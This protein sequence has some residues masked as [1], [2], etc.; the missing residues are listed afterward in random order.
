MTWNYR[1]FLIPSASALEEDLYVVK[2]V[3]YNEDDEIEYWSKDSVAP[4][5]S[6]VEDLEEELNKFYEAF[7]EPV[8]MEEGDTVVE[9]GGV[10]YDEDFDEPIIDVDLEDYH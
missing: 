2:E 3:Y 6:T 5:G 10:E 1:V 9:V 8:L 7:S 4:V